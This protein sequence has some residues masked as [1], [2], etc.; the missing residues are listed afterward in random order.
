M[1]IFMRMGSERKAVYMR[2]KEEILEDIEQINRAK[3]AAVKMQIWCV[4]RRAEL[5]K[6]LKE[7][8]EH[9]E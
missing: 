9:E 2:A 1:D 3:K 4:G 6:E 8:E 5:D 7:V